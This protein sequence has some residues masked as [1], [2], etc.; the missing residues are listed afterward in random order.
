MTLL[1][2]FTSFYWIQRYSNSPGNLAWLFLFFG[3][4]WKPE[5]SGNM[6][7]IGIICLLVSLITLIVNGFAAWKGITETVKKVVV[8][9]WTI[10]LLLML[11]NE[12][13]AIV[14][15]F[16]NSWESYNDVVGK[17]LIL[18]FLALNMVELAF[19]VYGLLTIKY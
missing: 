4:D 13:V 2:L 1:I 15:Y 3:F 12:I 5:L 9:C 6:T 19:W 7:T 14:A 8:A 16:S 18:T 10:C 11:V 17:K